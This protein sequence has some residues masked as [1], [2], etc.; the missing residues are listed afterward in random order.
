[1]NPYGRFAVVSNAVS[2]GVVLSLMGVSAQP[3][4]KVFNSAEIQTQTTSF[5]AGAAALLVAIVV[6]LSLSHAILPFFFRYTLIRRLILGRHYMEGT[7][8]QAEKSPDAPRM[9]II[10]IQPKGMSFRFSGYAV[11]DTL[12]VQ[13]NVALEFSHFDW[14]FMTYKFRNTLAETSDDSREGVG[15]IHFESNRQTPRS[16]N[17]FVQIVNRAGRTKIEGVRLRKSREIKELR[18]LEG[19]AEVIDHYWGLFFKRGDRSSRQALRQKGSGVGES[20][21]SRESE[22]VISLNESQADTADERSV[23]PLAET[24]APLKAELMQET[25]LRQAAEAGTSSEDGLATERRTQSVAHV[26]GPVV[27]R[28]RAEDWKSSSNLD[29]EVDLSGAAPVIRTRDRD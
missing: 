1:V 19:R 9:A 24:F 15:E 8:I 27:P 23:K 25:A 28:R 6:W 5:M 17:G 7:W 2:A 21:Q 12:E 26:D 22:P 20:E 14:P 18:S 10:E 16:Y 4:L 11:D 3:V 13:S 29:M